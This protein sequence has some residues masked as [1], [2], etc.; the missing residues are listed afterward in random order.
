MNEFNVAWMFPDTLFL[1]GERGNLLALA[2]YAQMAGLKPIVDKVDFSTEG[3]DPWAYDV[4]VFGPGE[5]SSFPQVMG[6]LY[7]HKE[8]LS[9]FVNEGRPLIATGTSVAMFCTPAQQS[10]P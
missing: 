1:H 2:R 10:Y 6:W 4:L 9:D 3:W 5:I 8:K 7:P